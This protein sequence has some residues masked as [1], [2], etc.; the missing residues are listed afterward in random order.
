M[1]APL[2]NQ[3]RTI[4]LSSV[5]LGTALSVCIAVSGQLLSSNQKGSR[6]K[7]FQGPWAFKVPV[8]WPAL[9]VAYTYKQDN[10]EEKPSK[11]NGFGMTY[12]LEG[13]LSSRIDYI[14]VKQGTRKPSGL[15]ESIRYS[16]RSAGFPFRSC[17]V[18][19]GWEVQSAT[20]WNSIEAPTLQ[21][22]GVFASSA[23]GPS[24][25]ARLPLD[26]KLLPVLLNAGL[27]TSVIVLAR[28]GI[29]Y[30][31]ARRRKFCGLCETCGYQTN[32]AQNCICPECGNSH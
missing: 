25:G 16:Q 19:D 12:R 17:L 9:P 8:D 13:V 24:L 26:W 32:L 1:R 7:Q 18:S 21:R 31:V 3:V 27:S 5:I 20:Q 14:F 10:S 28:V 4:L 2:R 23:A 11:I 15:T 29:W 30:A 22:G 6:G